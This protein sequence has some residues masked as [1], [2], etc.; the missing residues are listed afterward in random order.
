MQA[1]FSVTMFL[2]PHNHL[3][4]GE[5]KWSTAPL[6]PIQRS[7]V[8]RSVGKLIPHMNL[9]QQETP[10]KLSRSTPWYFELLSMSC[11]HGSGYRT[12]IETDGS[13]LNKQLFE[14]KLILYNIHSQVTWRRWN[15]DNKLWSGQ[16][17]PPNT[18]SAC[19][20][21]WSSV[22]DRE[23]GEQCSRIGKTNAAK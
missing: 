16:S 19:L 22:V 14:Y 23:T 9:D 10:C 7:A 21:S 17:W 2:L 1:I 20:R 3:R 6:R 13:S 4:R 11:D 15:N 12:L 18:P 5:L 8:K